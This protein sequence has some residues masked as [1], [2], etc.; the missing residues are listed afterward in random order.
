MFQDAAF[1]ADRSR[2]VYEQIRAL[3]LQKRTGIPFALGFQ[4][5]THVPL[6]RKQPKVDE[7]GESKK[8][9][10]QR[11][12]AKNA[13]LHVKRKFLGAHLSPELR[14]KHGKRSIELVIGDT[15]KVLRGSFKGK[16][17]KGDRVDVARTKV[18]LT[19]VERAKKDGS[20][21]AIP[22]NPSNVMI[23]ALK[24]D[25]AKRKESLARGASAA[26]AKPAAGSATAPAAA[27]GAAKGN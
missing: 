9:K 2:F 20:K 23:T 26:A 18:Y 16:E 8:P 11:K 13:A 17:T 25:D 24:L 19:G 15:V 4:E 3:D 7:G 6:T 5:V 27:A 12:Y 22:T 14:K 1:I 10:K 21:A